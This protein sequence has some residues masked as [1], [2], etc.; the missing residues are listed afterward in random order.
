MDYNNFRF[1]RKLNEYGMQYIHFISVIK[2]ILK[3]HEFY[4]YVRVFGSFFFFFFFFATSPLI[5]IEMEIC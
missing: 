2:H 4:F 1:N 5:L 3:Q